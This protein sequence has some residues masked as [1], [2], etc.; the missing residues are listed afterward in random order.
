M[1]REMPTIFMHILEHHRAQGPAP[2]RRR[3]P[4][5]HWKIRQSKLRLGI[6]VKC[7]I[8]ER[9]RSGILDFVVYS[10]VGCRSCGGE[11]VDRYPCKD[12]VVGPGIAVGPVVEL[13]VDPGEESYG[14]VGERYT[15]GGGFGALQGVV[16]EGVFVEPFGAAKHLPFFS[17]VRKQLVY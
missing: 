14:G 16:A 12:F 2:R 7:S 13:L 3:H 5:I 17:S 15:D 8:R 11:L 1:R 9:D 10:R 6:V 4:D